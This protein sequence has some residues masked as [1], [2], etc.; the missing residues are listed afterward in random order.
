MAGQ[1]NKDKMNS[2]PAYKNATANYN[3][4]MLYARAYTGAMVQRVLEEEP[5]FFEEK[6]TSREV[7]QAH[8]ENNICLGASKYR[9]SVVK[10]TMAQM[11]D[12]HYT[13]DQVRRLANGGQKF[14]PYF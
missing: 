12:D 10:N 1:S 7:F 14:H 5:E 9:A 8:L 6:G 11:T 4:C 13:T 3:N 2:Y